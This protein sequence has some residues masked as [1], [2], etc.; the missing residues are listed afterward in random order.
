MKLIGDFRNYIKAVFVE[1]GRWVFTI[2]DILGFILFFQPQLAESLLRDIQLTRTIGGSIF[3]L[4]FIFANFALYRRLSPQALDEQALRLY[5]HRTATS[6]AVLMK[7]VGGERV[8]DLVVTLS[9]KDKTGKPKKIKVTQF[10]SS[11]DSKMIYDIGPITSI[12]P[13]QETSFHILGKEENSEDKVNVQICFTGAKTGT[14]VKIERVF[15]L[16]NG[17]WLII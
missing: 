3:L 15:P 13:G 9:Y 16:V 4:S 14:Q 10:F 12:E 8:I 5:P 17:H 11:N 6:N 1:S 7:Y 2:F